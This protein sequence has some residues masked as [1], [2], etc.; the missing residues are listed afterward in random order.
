MKTT[1]KF[2]ILVLILG[3]IAIFNGAYIKIDG[4]QSANI[5]LVSGLLMEIISIVGLIF[6]NRKKILFILK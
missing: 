5:I 1:N 6:N 4:N 2:L 3:I